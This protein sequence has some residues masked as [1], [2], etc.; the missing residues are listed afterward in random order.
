M[1]DD[2]LDRMLAHAAPITDGQV[3][4]LGLRDAETELMEEI[5]ATT[6]TEVRLARTTGGPARGRRLRY[7]LVAVGAVAAAAAAAVLLVHDGTDGRHMAEAGSIRAADGTELPFLVPDDLPAGL[8]PASVAEHGQPEA[9]DVVALFGHATDGDLPT[10]DLVISWM[11]A[12]EDSTMVPDTGLDPVTVR[13]HDG[14]ACSGAACSAYGP[15]VQAAIEWTEQPGK[16][17]S[18]TSPS[19]T[20]DQLVA[21]ADGL[22]ITGHDAPPGS[23]PPGTVVGADDVRL[24]ELPDGLPGPLDA[25]GAREHKS[26]EIR[27]I[28]VPDSVPP[29][30][31]DDVVGPPDFL[32]VDYRLADPTGALTLAIEPGDAA[33]IAAQVATDDAQ[34]VDDVRGHPAWSATVPPGSGGGDVERRRLLWQEEPGVVVAVE[35]FGTDYDLD[36]LR[37]VAESLRPASTAEW[38]ALRD[39]A[40]D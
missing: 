30:W 24:G 10:V 9:W 33:D 17:F 26:G 2:E 19:L 38:Q 29:G 8:R 3:A 14:R 31:S 16:A 21:I 28:E 5:M 7:R 23:P 18:M 40:E 22:A 35:T 37:D 25:L 11:N 32:H 13:G 15:G 6:P 12:N 20:A 4:A 1:N 39:Q 34:P 36:V 27:P